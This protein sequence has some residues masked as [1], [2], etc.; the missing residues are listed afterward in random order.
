MLRKLGHLAAIS[1]VVVALSFGASAQS[2][3]ASDELQTW[4]FRVEGMT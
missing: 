3:D 2:S 1:L 4:L